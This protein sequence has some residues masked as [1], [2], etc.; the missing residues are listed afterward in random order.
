MVP[1]RRL[2]FIGPLPPPVHGQATTHAFLVERLRRAVGERLRVVDT[3]EKAHTGAIAQVVR[4]VRWLGVV[5]LVLVGW[6]RG[7]RVY[8]SLSANAGMYLNAAVAAA[9]R[10]TRQDIVVHHHTA[11]HLERPDRAMRW[12]SAAAGRAA[13]HIT[14]CPTMSS[15]LRALYP[16][17]E[18]TAELS[19]V[20]HVEAPPPRERAPSSAADELVLGMLS[21]LGFEKGVREAVATLE[22]LL[23]RGV[24]ARLVLAGPSRDSEVA[25]FLAAKRVE[26]GARLVLPGALYGA[27]KS[28]FFDAIDV[29]VFPTRYRHE[30]QGIVNL[31]ALAHGVPVMAYA[32]CCIGDDLADGGGLRVPVEA[33]FATAVA[34]TLEVYTRDRAALARAASAARAR[35]DALRAGG[36][37][38]LDVLVTTLSDVEVRPH[39]ASFAGDGPR[40]VPPPAALEERT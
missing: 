15:R 11:G 4:V 20:V 37:N 40:G 16:R 35:F 12:L 27:D 5:G 36:Q 10:W 2:L 23:A 33:D 26:L 24:P 34:A 28:A 38:Q 1:P 31:E 3:S 30:T 8:L 9:A 7:Q 17:V 32:R 13:L 39:G 25:A 21:N 6:P 19:N 29:F 14:I 18:R 22:A